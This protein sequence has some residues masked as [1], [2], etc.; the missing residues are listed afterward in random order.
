MLPSNTVFIY[1]INENIL[2]K[3]EFNENEFS[4]V[5]MHSANYYP[6]K[7]SI[8]IFGGFKSESLNNMYFYNIKT[9]KFKQI[10]YKSYKEEKEIKMSEMNQLVNLS[11]EDEK[12]VIDNTIEN[13]K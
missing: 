3:K 13:I 5:C 12:N 2:E 7:K 1:N 10:K 9:N 6:K 11:N 4:G 8:V